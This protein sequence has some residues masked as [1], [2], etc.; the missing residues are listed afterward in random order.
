[1]FTQIV[2]LSRMETEDGRHQG[3]PLIDSDTKEQYLRFV[4]RKD[5]AI[6]TD[7]LFEFL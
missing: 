5:V 2:L 1:M 6:V 7:T 4:P 3:G